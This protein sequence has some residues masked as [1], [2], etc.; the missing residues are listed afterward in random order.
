M[1][2]IIK[3]AAIAAVATIGVIGTTSAASAAD[4]GTVSYKG[5]GF[6]GDLINNDFPEL[7]TDA[8]KDGYLLWVLGA[9]GAKSAQLTIPAVGTFNMVAKNG[10]FKV[11][12]PWVNRSGLVGA[13]ATYT[14]TVK[15]NVTLTVSHGHQYVAPVEEPPVVKVDT[16]IPVLDVNE[17]NGTGTVP[18]S[19]ITG[20]NPVF[21]VDWTLTTDKSWLTSDATPDG[22][23]HRMT[24]NTR[25]Y[26]VNSTPIIGDQTGELLGWTLIGKSDVIAQT[27]VTLLPG[28]VDYMYNVRIPIDEQQTHASTFDLKVNN[29]DLI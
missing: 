11:E 14:G 5:N 20:D 4:P 22:R 3:A 27:P 19:E 24:T 26:A 29:I 1:N 2:R 17:E 8:A 13:F 25:T 21:T 18:K 9:N 6:T 16:N 28:S 23:H 12:T 10:S 7:E 15:G